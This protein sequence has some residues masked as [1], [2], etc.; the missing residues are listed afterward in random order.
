[1]FL[2]INNPD[3]FF[4]LGSVENQNDDDVCF[5]LNVFQ[6]L[7]CVEEGKHCDIS[8]IHKEFNRF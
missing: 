4:F 2:K 7:F 6:S 3:C 1:M 8:V 5:D